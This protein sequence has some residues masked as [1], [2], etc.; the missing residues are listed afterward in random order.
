[1]HHRLWEEQHGEEN[2][3][4]DINNSEDDTMV[5]RCASCDCAWGKVAIE[6]LDCVPLHTV[7]TRIT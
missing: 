7:Y 1:M 2:I 6:D 4:D 3:E 5:H